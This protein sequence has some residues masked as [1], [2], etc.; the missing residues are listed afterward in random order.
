MGSSELVVYVL[1]VVFELLVLFWV[2]YFA[3]AKIKSS[4]L[5]GGAESDS[6]FGQ[7]SPSTFRFVDPD[8]VSE[9]MGNYKGV[10]IYRY[11]V[12]GG[13]KFQFEHIFPSE[14]VVKIEKGAR[15]LAPGLVY[16]PVLKTEQ[17]SE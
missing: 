11:A 1:F 16:L 6:F 8:H 10:Q 5:E 3:N 4:D 13:V 17:K 14:G 2:T 7:A 15:C 9:P 12:I